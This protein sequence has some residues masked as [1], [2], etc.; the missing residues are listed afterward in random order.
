[1]PSHRVKI[2]FS[3]ISNR[4]SERPLISLKLR[5]VNFRLIYTEAQIVHILPYHNRVLDYSQ[6][7]VEC[8][9]KKIFSY[10]LLTALG[11]V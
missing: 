5:Y 1:M 4:L 11:Q 7:N 8:K 9:S 3:I 10:P 6:D 2:N